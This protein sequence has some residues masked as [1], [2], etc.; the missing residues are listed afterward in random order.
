M[1]GRHTDDDTLAADAPARNLFWQSLVKAG[2]LY[3]CGHD[4]FYDRM[5]VVRTGPNLGREVFQITAGTAGAP[6]YTGGEHAGS[7]LWTLRRDAHFESVYGYILVEVDGEKATITF[8]GNGPSYSDKTGQ[9]AFAAL[10]QMVCESSGC[11]TVSCQA[12]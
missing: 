5:S 4:H 12:P 6:F 7:A 10:D 8:K 11:K 1:A 3:F 9:L 2:A